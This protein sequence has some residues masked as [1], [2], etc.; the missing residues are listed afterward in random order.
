M[1]GV[2]WQASRRKKRSGTLILATGPLLRAQLLRLAAEEHVL[3]LNDAPHRE[4]R[5]VAWRCWSENCRRLYEAYAQGQP[6]P[7]AELAIQ[8]ADY[9]VWQR[10]WLQGEVLE[11]QLRVLAASSWRERRQCWSCRR[12]IRGRR[13]RASGA[14]GSRC[15]WSH[16]VERTVEGVEPAR[17]SDAVHDAAGGVAGVAVALQRTGRDRGGDADSGTDSAGDGRV[18]RVLCEH[19]GAADVT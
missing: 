19:A 4:R 14:D 2:W 9:A 3:L 6:S 5:L 15:C 10:E 12:I 8:Y 13:C 18:D 17:R 11:E 16:G 1:R 7:L